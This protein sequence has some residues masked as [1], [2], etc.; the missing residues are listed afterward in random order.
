MASSLYHVARAADWDVDTA[1]YAPASLAAEGFIHLSTEEQVCETA[2]RFFAG[3]ADLV[4]LRVDPD[5]VG[6]LRWEP[7]PDGRGVFPH[8]YGPLPKVAVVAATPWRADS[9]GAWTLPT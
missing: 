6:D 5:L 9:D 4:L 1:A 2:A 3:A 7:S 8:L